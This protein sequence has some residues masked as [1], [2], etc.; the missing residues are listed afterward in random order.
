MA[1]IILQYLIC[2]AGMVGFGLFWGVLI[3]A[4][5]RQV[6]LVWWKS[7]LKITILS[8]VLG[9]VTILGICL[10]HFVFETISRIQ[11]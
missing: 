1:P 8:L 3:V 10:Y 4:V 5:E 9:H 6:H 7:V 11:Q 2:L